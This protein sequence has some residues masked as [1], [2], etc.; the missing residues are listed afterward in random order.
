MIVLALGKTR[1][2]QI[3]AHDPAGILRKS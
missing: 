1:S 3:F 2:P